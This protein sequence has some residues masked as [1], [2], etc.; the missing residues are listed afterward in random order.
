MYHQYCHAV[1][2]DAVCHL[3][4][5][6][7]TATQKEEEWKEGEKGEEVSKDTHCHR[8]NLHRRNVQRAGL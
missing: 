2:S 7:F 6:V 3:H 4:F 5:C 8:W 1:D